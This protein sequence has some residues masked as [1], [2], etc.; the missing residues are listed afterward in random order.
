MQFH[1][2]EN[3]INFSSE[4]KGSVNCVIIWNSA[5]QWASLHAQKHPQ[6]FD[7]LIATYL[8]ITFEFEGRGYR[9][10]YLVLRYQKLDF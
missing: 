7:E 8:E 4:F 3:N 1:K 2:V 10:K 5:A 9:M 6:C